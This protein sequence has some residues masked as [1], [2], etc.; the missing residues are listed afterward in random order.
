MLFTLILGHVYREV[1]AVNV[2]V[3]VEVGTSGQLPV[4]Q[5]LVS[6]RMPSTVQVKDVQ[7]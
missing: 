2:N 7:G 4:G 5:T 3:G 1:N 6:V